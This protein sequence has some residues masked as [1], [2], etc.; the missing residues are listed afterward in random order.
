MV[1]SHHR[2]GAILG[3]ALALPGLGGVAHAQSAPTEGQFAFKY[4]YYKDSQPDLDRITVKSPSVYALFPISNRWSLEGSL[5][6]DSLSGATPRWH[7][8]VSSASV[9]EDYRVAGDVKLTRYFERSAWGFGMAASTEDDYDSIAVSTDFRISTADNNVTLALG[10]GY[11][12]DE[13]NSTGGAVVGETKKVLDLL[14]GGTFILTPNDIARVNL[15]HARGSGFFT[16]PYKLPDR[17]PRSRN[18]TALLT[19]WNHYFS[20][21]GAALRSSYRFYSDSWKIAAHTFGLDWAQSVGGG[22]SVTPGLRYHTQSSAEFYCD[23]Q[24]GLPVP[25]ACFAVPANQFVSADHRL[26]AFGAVTAGLKLSYTI[27]KLTLDAKYEYYQQRSD[28]RIG[29]EGSPGLQPFRANMFQVGF[30]RTF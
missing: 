21:A 12:S 1:R 10:A 5:V 8:S 15:T 30:T 23:A 26:S 20:G 24:P 29:G 9:M 18:S 17:R 6:T 14:V 25:L 2:G 27:A 22:W 7:S 4:L 11:T 13:I 28:W 16:D 3:A 19:Q